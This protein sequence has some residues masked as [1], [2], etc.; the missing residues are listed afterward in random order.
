MADYSDIIKD[1]GDIPDYLSNDDLRKLINIGL[2]DIMRHTDII[3]NTA[4]IVVDIT[5]HEKIGSSRDI[6]CSVDLESDSEVEINK[7]VV[8]RTVVEPDKQDDVISINTQF[9]D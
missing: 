2:H 9:T 4:K 8:R 7:P 3:S 6:E 1:I 5:V